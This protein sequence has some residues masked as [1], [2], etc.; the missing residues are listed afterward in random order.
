MAAGENRTAT[1]SKTTEV[2]PDGEPITITGEGF[3]PN[4]GIY[5]TLCVD[6][7]VGHLSSPCLGGVDM[8]GEA[9]TSA[10]ISSNPPSYGEGLATPYGPNGSFSVTLQIAAADQFVDCR[11]PVAA[12]D[13]CVIYMRADHT[14]TS[15]RSQDFRIPVSFSGESDDDS[16][17]DDS[18][19][20][21]GTKDESNNTAGGKDDQS[22][23]D[24]LAKTGV[25]IIGVGILA[26]V[27]IAGGAIVVVLG[28]RGGKG[29]KLTAMSAGGVVLGALLVGPAAGP[30]DAAS[31][32]I[33]SGT[34]TWGVKESLRTHVLSPATGGEV[35]ATGDATVL[36]DGRFEF[37]ANVDGSVYD[38]LESARSFAFGGS[39]RLSGHDL[40]DGPL[41]DITIADPRLVIDSAGATLIADVTGN[42][43]AGDGSRDSAEITPG[44]VVRYDDVPLVDVDVTGD[45][46]MPGQ[47]GTLHVNE[48]ATTLTDDGAEALAGYYEPGTAL[49]PV[50]FTVQLSAVQ[51]DGAPN[52]TSGVAP[53]LVVSL[54][55]GDVEQGS[56]VVVSGSGYVPGRA[57][58][59][60][61]TPE[62][63]AA[64]ANPSPFAHSKRVVASADG[65][66][67][68]TL[69]DVRPVFTNE[70]ANVD[71]SVSQCHVASFGSP[72]QIDNRAAEQSADRSQD[73]F[74]PVTF[75]P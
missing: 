10:W 67:T 7:G 3:D 17:S 46:L 28:T 56:D 35:K 60:A 73:V 1:A 63:E 31:L 52:E 25:A 5:V 4:K 47:D 54:P 42:E 66:F 45:D 29:R 13:G 2:D 41:L 58:F 53:T 50:S 8:S 55:G 74:V 64:G 15:D 69:E 70:D 65:T 22:K 51:A 18:A 43:S 59:V 19:G 16:E 38:S 9:G 32:E 23:D 57:V 39:V 24:D 40:G 6:E 14:R 72:L 33:E 68:T 30:V 12:P 49:D 61:V 20:G 34:L 44:P 26:I 48:A 37:R 75:T 62:G 27:L 21:S 11:D 71:C 36:D